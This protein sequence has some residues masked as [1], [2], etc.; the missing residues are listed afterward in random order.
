MAIATVARHNV[1]NRAR[2]TVFHCQQRMR[3]AILK[4][5]F[6]GTWIVSIPLSTKA[7]TMRSTGAIPLTLTA[8]LAAS[9]FFSC[10]D[11]NYETYGKVYM[12][13]TISL[14]ELWEK[15]EE[16]KGEVITLELDT[17][18][19]VGAGSFPKIEGF[20]NRKA[21]LWYVN[22][23]GLYSVVDWMKFYKKHLDSLKR[24]RYVF[25]GS[26]EVN[27]VNGKDGGI[28]LPD[29]AN[30]S[31]KLLQGKEF[32]RRVLPKTE[33]SASKTLSG[34]LIGTHESVHPLPCIEFAEGKKRVITIAVTGVRREKETLR[35]MDVV[36]HGEECPDS[37]QSYLLDR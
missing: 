35:T 6:D 2:E 25:A 19:G 22:D 23:Y 33:Y 21:Q 7:L 17:L 4:Y 34:V 10:A 28:E 29:W 30:Y 15:R 13:K 37:G 31:G 5:Y 11:P 26:Y 8:L 32:L 20:K 14:A 36:C 27:L 16:L 24:N 1:P 9:I 18:E 12:N 3:H